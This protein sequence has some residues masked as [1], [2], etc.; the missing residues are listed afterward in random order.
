MNH[1]YCIVAHLFFGINKLGFFFFGPVGTGRFVP[2]KVRQYGRLLL[3]YYF[4][5]L[6]LVGLGW[7]EDVDP[8]DGILGFAFGA[9][10]AT[11][12]LGAG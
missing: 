9:V 11:G 7:L 1:D 8:F 6:T 2:C 5:L 4:S 10:G 12:R 3:I